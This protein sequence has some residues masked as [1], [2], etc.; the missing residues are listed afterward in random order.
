MSTIN[1]TQPFTQRVATNVAHQGELSNSEILLAIF[2][3]LICI[4]DVVCS[5][6]LDEYG[7][8]VVTTESDGNGDTLLG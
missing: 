4:A 1:R 7:A 5:L 6:K 2:E 8:L 3:Q